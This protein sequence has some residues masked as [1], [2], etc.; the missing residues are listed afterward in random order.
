V[1]DRRF[2]FP[3]PFGWFMACYE[4]ELD[5]EGVVRERLVGRDLVVWRGADGAPHVFDAYCPHLGAHLGVGGRVDDDGC[6]VCPFHEWAF[7][8]AGRNVRIPYASKPNRKARVRSF[9]TVVR[10]GLVLFWYHPDLDVHPMW[11]LPE[12]VPDEFVA[13]GTYEWTVGTV[14]QEVAE[15]SV[16]MAHFASVHGLTR[17]ADIGEV[18]VDGPRRQINSTQSFNTARGTFEGALQSNSYGPGVGVTHFDLMG[19]VTLLS[20]TTPV[21]DDAV[22][23][24]FHLFHSPD[25]VAAKIAPRFADEVKRQF[26]QDIPIW[27]AKRYVPVPALAPSEKAVTEFRRWASQFYAEVS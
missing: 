12:L 9:P 8:G 26:D 18:V 1:R 22:R 7:D 6:L 15:N 3:L 25:D 13:C 10:N 16:D 5:G 17:V 21:E 20:A 23:V 24:R 27:E 2:P 14:W 4:R 19:R 11:D